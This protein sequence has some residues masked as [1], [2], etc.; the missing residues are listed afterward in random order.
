MQIKIT[1]N[2]TLTTSEV[3]E[4]LGVSKATVQNWSGGERGRIPCYRLPGGQRRFCAGDIVAYM[5]ARAIPV[6][7]DLQ[8]L[9]VVSPPADPPLAA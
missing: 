7:D 2:T 9:I 5:Q 3:A 1:R 4:L 6:P 8:H